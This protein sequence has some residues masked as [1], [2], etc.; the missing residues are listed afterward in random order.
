MDSL[1]GIALVGVWVVISVPCVRPTAHASAV[2]SDHLWKI[3]ISD[4]TGSV[5]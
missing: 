2:E 5:R 1:L 3:L 4:V